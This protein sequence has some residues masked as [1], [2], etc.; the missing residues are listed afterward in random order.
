MRGCLALA[1]LG[2]YAAFGVAILIIN[3]DKPNTELEIALISSSS[4]ALAGAT[5]FFFGTGTDRKSGPPRG[6]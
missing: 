2:V 5:G 4:T 1:L 3:R 6:E